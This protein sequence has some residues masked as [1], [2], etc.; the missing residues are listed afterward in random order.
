MHLIAMDPLDLPITTSRSG[1]A[2][3]YKLKWFKHPRQKIIL[4]WVISP[5]GTA[6]KKLSCRKEGKPCKSKS[7]MGTHPSKVQGK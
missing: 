5:K 3:L 4:G 6:A 2:D 1:T 7:R